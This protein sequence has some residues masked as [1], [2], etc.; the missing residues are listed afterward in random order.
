MKDEEDAH[1]DSH[2]Q[3]ELDSLKV[4]MACIVSLLKQTLR[5]IFGKG[6]SNH[7]VTFAQTQATIQLEE[8]MSEHG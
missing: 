2:F 5:N 4:C 6:P 3:E 1:C 8:R 7:V